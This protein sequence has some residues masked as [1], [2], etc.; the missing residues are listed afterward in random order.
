VSYCVCVCYHPPQPV[1]HASII[2]ELLHNN[3]QQLTDQFP[4]DIIV[5][6]G[7]L[8]KLS[9]ADLLA[10]FGLSQIVTAPTRLH[11]ILDVFITNRPTCLNALLPRLS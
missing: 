7:D 3:L 10:D 5:L 1:Y 4:T 2:T 9:Y 6:A 11:N 8:N